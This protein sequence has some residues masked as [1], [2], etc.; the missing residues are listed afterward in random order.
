MG[1]EWT[2]DAAGRVDLRSCPHSALWRRAPR[3][4]WEEDHDG[5]VHGHLKPNNLCTAAHVNGAAY[6]PGL[7]SRGSLWP[8][9]SHFETVAPDRKPKIPLGRSHEKIDVNDTILSC[10]WCAAGI[11]G[12]NGH[13]HW[14]T[15]TTSS[16][17]L[18]HLLRVWMECAT[19]CAIAVFICVR[20]CPAWHVFGSL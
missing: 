10:A 12:D 15:T 6:P 14:L 11:G 3:T 18:P 4:G 17:H 19:C 9:P 8:T 7:T 13:R 20:L 5:R 2:C 1:C 16:W